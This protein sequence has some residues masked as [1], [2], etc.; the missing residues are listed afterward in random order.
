MDAIGESEYDR[1][2][3]LVTALLCTHEPSVAWRLV[4][5]H[6][7]S[8]HFD[9][10]VFTAGEYSMEGGT[11]RVPHATPDWAWQRVPHPAELH[12]LFSNNPFVNQLA[13]AADRLAPRRCSDAISMS[14]WMNSAA[15][16]QL[17][18]RLGV[19]YQLAIPL[20]PSGGAI[21]AVVLMRSGHDFSERDLMAAIKLQGLLLGLDANLCS[22]NPSCL[23]SAAGE[24][25]PPLGCDVHLTKG[26]WRFSDCLPLD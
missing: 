20:R 7:L 6:F 22:S 16:S 3:D 17:R 8:M 2:L 23:Q 13:T 5:E 25:M 11:S 12:E 10:E 4:G 18:A 9:A 19:S 26:K 24:R 1:L 21:R 15:R 14:A